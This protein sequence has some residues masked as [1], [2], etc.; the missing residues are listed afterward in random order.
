MKKFLVK[1]GRPIL[2]NARSDVLS[3][4][5]YIE[6]APN[7]FR[8]RKHHWV[9]KVPSELRTLYLHTTIIMYDSRV[10]L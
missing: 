8:K 9:I 6:E 7:V 2:R 4:M 5:Q 1:F 3:K 10:I